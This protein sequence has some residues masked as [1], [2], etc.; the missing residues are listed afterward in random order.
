M[1]PERFCCLSLETGTLLVAGVHILFST[2]NMIFSILMVN[3]SEMEIL[4]DNFQD[5]D[6]LINEY[7]L[8]DN[9]DL[10]FTCK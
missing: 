4:E 9:W 10:F 6:Q 5:L 3:E 1:K 2:I 7:N 8:F